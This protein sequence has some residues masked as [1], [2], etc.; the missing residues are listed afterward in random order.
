MRLEY[1]EFEID[2]DPSR[3]DL[4]VVWGF[5][6][7]EA[8]WG[9]FRKRSDVEGQVRGS[10]RVLG[11]YRLADGSQV[12]FARAFG[13]GHTSAYLADVFVL[14]EVRGRGLGKA[15]I[16]TMIDRGPGAN[17][18]WMLHTDDAHELYA[19][20]GFVRPNGQ[21]LERPP[22]HSDYGEREGTGSCDAS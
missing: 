16:E 6:S 22:R 18:R 21:F 10:W 14:G 3:V 1:G 9:R 2:D 11:A 15:L 5:L 20:F 13:D 8:Y 17:F 7:T 19:R 12:G 4:D